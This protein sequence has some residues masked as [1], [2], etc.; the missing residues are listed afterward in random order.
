MNITRKNYETIFIDFLEGNLDPSQVRELM[1]F[2]EENP[3][4]KA[5]IDLFQ[6]TVIKDVDEVSFPERD[7]LKKKYIPVGEINANNIEFFLIDR[8]EGNADEGLLKDIL[9]FLELNPDFQ[10]EWKKIKATKLSADKAV[11]FQGKEKLKKRAVIVPIRIAGI[12]AASVA[13]II[14]LFFGFQNI[15][16]T[17]ETVYTAENERISPYSINVLTFELQTGSDIV[18]GLRPNSLTFNYDRPLE[19][20]P[21]TLA[22]MPRK[23]ILSVEY[24]SIYSGFDIIAPFPYFMEDL[25]FNEEPDGNRENKKNFIGRIFS[26]LVTKTADRLENVE[27]RRDARG[28]VDFW[29]LA[30]YG[31]KGYNA[32]A[33]KDISLETQRNEDGKVSEYSLLN[34]DDTILNKKRNLKE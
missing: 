28:N 14:L 16:I 6:E 4:L 9:G 26:N 2:L 25:A 15:F 32:I 1:V 3:D 18:S 12:A 19:R 22:S 27:Q 8:L 30:D 24:P 31:L 5:E 29:T 10:S 13:A 21:G 20:E 7:K 23:E 17:N 33:D 34:E 11:V